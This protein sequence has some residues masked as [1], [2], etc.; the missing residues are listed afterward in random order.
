METKKWAN[1]LL[2]FLLVLVMVVGM[3]PTI[4]MT[5]FAEEEGRETATPPEVAK[6]L[7]PNGDGTYTLSLSVT[8]NASSSTTSNKADV[9]VV[10]D[11]SGSMDYDQAGH[12]PGS[13]QY[14]GPSR[15]AVA[16]EAVNSLAEEL[17]SNNTAEDPDKVQLSL[18]TFSDYATTDITGTT[19]LN[20]FRNSVN[21]IDANGGTNWEDGLHD[22]NAIATRDGANVYVIFVSD[23][24]PTF[25][26]TKGGGGNSG[27]DRQHG[28][29]PNIY[30]GSGNSDNNGKNFQY[31]LEQARAIVDAGKNLY[32]IGAFGDADRMQAL[33]TQSGAPASN[34]YSAADQAALNAAFTNIV[35]EITNAFGYNNVSIN[36][37]LT[38]MTATTL[39]AGQ[40]DGFTYTR[41]GGSYGT[42]ETW[43]EAPTASYDGSA[44]SWDLGNMTLE[45]SVTYTVSFR[46]WPKQ[47]AYDLVADLNNGLITYDSLTDEQKAQIVALDGGGYALK[48]NT[49][50]SASYT[51]SETITTSVL[52]EGATP[53]PDGSYE[54][55]GYTY[56]QNPDGT[57]TGRKE[58]PGEASF[59][60]PDPMALTNDLMT[61]R[62]DW[63]DSLDPSQRPE[64]VTLRIRRDDD[65]Y[66]DIVLNEANHWTVQLDVAPGLIAGGETLE[67]GHDYTVEELD[68][69]YHFDLNASPFHPM[70][71]DGV[72]K[73]SADDPDATAV[74]T[75][76]NDLRGG[77]NINKD[78]T[79]DEGL[80]A[81]ADAEFRFTVTL[82]KA[83]GTPWTAGNYTGGEVDDY[84][85]SYLK[86]RIYY[87]DGTRSEKMMIQSGSVITLKAGDSARIINVPAGT[88][89]YAVEESDLPAGFTLVDSEGTSGTITANSGPVASF[90]NNYSVSTTTASIPV[91][92]ILSL[93]EGIDPADHDITGLYTFTL[94][95]EDGAPLPD[96]TQQTNPDPDGGTVVFGDITYT[97]PGTYTYHVAETGTVAGVSN[98]PQA[99]NKTVVVVVTDNGDGTLTA[100]VQGADGTAQAP[101]TETTFTNTYSVNEVTA[102]IP[103]TKALVVPAGQTGPGN[104]A[105]Q[106]TFTIEDDPDDDVDS[107][108]PAVPSVT[109]PTA[110]G[111]TASFGSVTYTQPGTYSYIIKE[112]GSVTGVTNDGAA[113]S[114]KKVQVVVS[115]NGDGTL[116]AV[117]YGA[118]STPAD[119][120]AS[121]TFTNTYNATPANASI[122]VQKL[123]NAA[124]G[125][126]PPDITG[127]YTFT[128]AAETA[129]A[130]LPEVTSLTNPDADGGTV[131][132]GDITY[133]KVGVYTYTVSES[134]TVAGVV[135]DNSGT[136]R[137]TVTVT[138]NGAGVLS[139]QVSVSAEKPVTFINTYSVRP[140]TAT[141]P[142]SKLLELN[143]FD[144]PDSIK[145]SYTFILTPQNGAPGAVMTVSNPDADGGTANF[146]A[147]TF[148]APGTYTYKIT[149]SGNVAG[150]TND[151]EAASGKIVT[152]IVTDNGDGTLTAVVNGADGQ[153][154]DTTFTNTYDAS[155][156]EAVIPVTKA[157]SYGSGL[158]PPDITGRYT[159]TLTPEDGAPAP[160]DGA[161]VVN[162]DADGGS[163]EF[164]SITFTKPGTY[165]YT[166][167]EE[168]TVSG[169][170]NDPAASSGKT[171]TVIVTDNKDGTLSVSVHG[172]DCEAAYI[173]DDTTFTNTYSV[174][175]VKAS[176]PVTKVLA[177]AEGL[178][179][180][181]ITEEYTFTLAD[182]ADD[183]TVSPLPETT[184][185]RNPDADGGSVT[186]GE[187]EYDVPGMYVYTVTESGSVDGV[188]NDAETVKRIMVLV[189]DNGDGTLAV[190]VKGADGTDD[191]PSENTTFTNTYAVTSTTLSFP[192]KKTLSVPEGLSAPDITELYTFTLT[193]EDGA[194]LPETTTLKNPDADGGTV[195]F[196][197]ITYTEPGTYIYKVTESGT[198]PGVTN[199]SAAEKT[200][201]VTVRDNGD[202]TLTAVAD[203]TDE[204]PLEFVNS[205]SVE[206]VQASITA[207]KILRN[208]VLDQGAFS[209]VL[210]APDGTPMPASPNATNNA[211]GTV[212]FGSITYTRPGTYTYTV[213]EVVGS[214]GYYTYDESSYTVTV[215]VT[216]NHDGTMTAVVTG[217]GEEATFTNTY[218]A[219]SD[220]IVL[221][222]AKQVNGQAAALNIF[223]FTLTADDGGML[224]EVTTVTND[225]GSV[226]FGPIKYDA[227]IFADDPDQRV[228]TY[229]YTITEEQ[230]DAPGYTYD[231]ANTE[232][233]TVTV[234]DNGDGTLTASVEYD[235][236]DVTFRNIYEAE[237]EVELTA[238]KVLEGDTEL[239]EGQ[240]SFGLFEGQ[241]Q[242][243][244][245]TN[246]ADG[247]ISFIVNYDQDDVGL[248]TYTMRELVDNP[249]DGYTYDSSVKTVEVMVTDNGDGT[250]SAEVSYGEDMIFT[251]VYKPLPTEVVLTAGKVLTGKTL[252]DGEFTF[253]LTDEDG[254]L[255]STA[256]NDAEGNI[257]FPAIP[258]TEAGTYTFRVSE[259]SGD[260]FGMSYDETEYVYNVYVGDENGRLVV[261]EVI[262]DEGE[263]VFNNVFTKHEPHVTIEKKALN[264][265]ASGYK[266]GDEIKYEITVINDG[267]TILTNV[268]VSDPLT[269]D[270]WTVDKLEIGE[271]K[272]FY[273]TYRVTEADGK[274]GEVLNTA[275]VEAD[276]PDPDN[277]RVTGRDED[278][279]KVTPDV[280]YTGDNQNVWLWVLIA[281]IAV[282]V[283]SIMLR[284]RRRR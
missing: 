264:V 171:V 85:E 233:V 87:A 190:T 120:K 194:P 207:R 112:S 251:N 119:P 16:K 158:T 45:N 25:R 32:T 206:P 244:T 176:I 188:T 265:P 153:G 114:G 97:K 159:F 148:T 237:G 222:A 105:G 241:E 57:W 195:S 78:V 20:R 54:F 117:I 215:E 175:S 80:T 98:D 243:G 66:V 236:D 62:K 165:T 242:V 52:P 263:A 178:T 138:D 103:V 9:I 192:V 163:A 21:A 271:K 13:W 67:P 34:Y 122:P 214:A 33:A 173:T 60:E 46:V 89:Y 48:T 106:Y 86:Y 267:D 43:D 270:T 125:L 272:T 41:S 232:G 253:R 259:V 109:N 224:P 274:N 141:I 88:T 180:P 256:T 2:S 12:A 145:N 126:T 121:T 144:G 221:H 226:S 31:A 1:R 10:F 128:L 146:G 51:Q 260:R 278:S 129:G 225:G 201:T 218:N 5:A 58:I 75:A 157:L 280:P 213:T 63:N 135:N 143:G 55:D 197:P 70:I 169:I 155:P 11:R 250:L 30:Y 164:G 179:P 130:P 108:L 124:A 29:W 227:S 84:D 96:V 208:A 136:K 262:V 4:F 28:T 132:F 15:L 22:A 266:V 239:L 183:E 196:G 149:E 91:N 100:Q 69:D 189:T 261:Q 6:T 205:Y 111:G 268:V 23:G 44:V 234:T 177:A 283:I 110:T 140:T 245:A 18:V 228:K 76:I 73:S 238:Q 113:Q 162:P 200:V 217:D 231:V 77:L 131:V 61:I 152:V 216:D 150:V 156:A 65:T 279:E 248:H 184:E 252:E 8:G 254:K 258:L 161:T 220:E 235:D 276:T 95:A 27:E 211:D 42:G 40:P 104:I 14:Q 212:S 193:G 35:N 137:V 7:T 170:S 168:G 72:L 166:I 160:A 26:N 186:F 59:T 39:V 229:H 281:L 209:F 127:S 185:L 147:I 93:P 198:V 219:E 36:D 101:S 282:M 17:L 24:N 56:T 74:F 107:P 199:D 50:A 99:A 167:T 139:A 90:T 82:T 79:A 49:S 37:G 92:K 249:E 19:S 240:F 47:E 210:S 246:G 187:I 38:E 118:D 181:D 142:V 230:G 247:T 3:M 134:G 182:W 273:A 71:V 83:D 151:P 154:A 275:T 174:G 269:G 202:G 257:T 115:D 284:L 68:G 94:T 133:T 102:A 255:I 191:E 81:P 53:N 172:A 64:S 203:S 123:L 223:R 277:P 116:S 204:E